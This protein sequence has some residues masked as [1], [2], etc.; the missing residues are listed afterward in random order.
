MDTEV[1]IHA[2]ETLSNWP[3]IQSTM[4]S[5]SLEVRNSFNINE[6]C[7]HIHNLFEIIGM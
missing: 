1:K 3:V 6:I 5:L 7:D 2:Y 4:M